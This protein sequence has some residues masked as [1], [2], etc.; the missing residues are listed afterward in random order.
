M[1][2]YLKAGMTDVG[3]WDPAVIYGGNGYRPNRGAKRRSMFL[4]GVRANRASPNA[5]DFRR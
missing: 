5:H 2:G 3:I 4:D 1:V